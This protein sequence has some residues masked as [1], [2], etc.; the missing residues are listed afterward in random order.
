MAKDDVQN[1]GANRDRVHRS[2]CSRNRRGGSGGTPPTAI[3]ALGDDD[4]L[5]VPGEGAQTPVW[6]GGF[7]DAAGRVPEKRLFQPGLVPTLR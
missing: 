3:V 6:D 1:G 4:G 5:G 7:V 2:G